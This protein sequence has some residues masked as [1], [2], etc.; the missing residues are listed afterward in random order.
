MMWLSA[1]LITLPAAYG[2]LD[3]SPLSLGKPY[4]AF[5]VGQGAPRKTGTAP[6]PT[7]P[8]HPGDPRSGVVRDLLLT[9]RQ[10]DPGSA[11]LR[12]LSGMTP[13]GRARA[14]RAFRV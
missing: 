4:L 1:S 2:I 14:V 12:G 9:R 8:C 13:V 10:A 6:S 11:P 7:S 5:E 3:A